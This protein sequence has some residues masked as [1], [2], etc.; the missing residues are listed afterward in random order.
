M[1]ERRLGKVH[2]PRDKPHPSF[3]NGLLEQTDSGGIAA[4][5]LV[6]KGV[7]NVEHAAHG[8]ACG[9]RRVHQLG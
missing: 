6:G 5:W 7:N 4:K 3:V 9:S 8:G 2:F 1:K